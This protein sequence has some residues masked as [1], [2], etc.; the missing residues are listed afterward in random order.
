MSF[1]P[2]YSILFHKGCI[3]NRFKPK[4][5]QIQ[6]RGI[7]EKQTLIKIFQLWFTVDEIDSLKAS[8]IDFIDPAVGTFNTKFDSGQLVH[9]VN[10]PK[11]NKY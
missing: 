7:I 2:R 6:Q 3:I 4:T 5:D 1:L 8:V 10:T 9:Y 11:L